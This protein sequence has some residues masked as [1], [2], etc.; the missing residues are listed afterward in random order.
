MV[1]DEEEGYF[2]VYLVGEEI[3]CYFELLYFVNLLINWECDSII[4]YL[5]EVEMLKNSVS[6]LVY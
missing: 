4:N 3:Y 6:W 2:E 1:G 5:F